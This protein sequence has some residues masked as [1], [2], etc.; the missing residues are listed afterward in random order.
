MA[1]KRSLPVFVL[2]IWF[3]VL[4][5]LIRD[6]N[7]QVFLRPDFKWLIYTGMIISLIMAAGLIS[8]DISRMPVQK[9]AWI[10]GLILLLPIGF[11][12]TAGESTLGEYALSKRVMVLPGSSE[13]PV[14][15]VDKAPAPLEV[16][17]PQP[18]DNDGNQVPSPV[19]IST[20]VREFHQYDGKPVQVEGLFADTID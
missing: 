6:D 20:L 10:K 15:P 12:F 2:A 7:Y 13:S 16:T 1:V 5:W 19:S 17:L 9:Q 14:N 3:F 8:G 4:A 11:I 18:T